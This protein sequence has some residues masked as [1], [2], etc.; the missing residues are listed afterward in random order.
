M[1]QINAS[2]QKKRVKLICSI[3]EKEFVTKED[4]EDE[5]T[6]SCCV[7]GN[8]YPP[9]KIK[10]S[11]Y[12]PKLCENCHEGNIPSKGG[13]IMQRRLLSLYGEAIRKESNPTLLTILM[14]K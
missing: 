2:S 1:V 14:K 4:F 5:I 7:C 8:N 10:I 3:C 13:D 11:D 12:I 6:E 9:S